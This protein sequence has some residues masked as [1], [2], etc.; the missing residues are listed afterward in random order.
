MLSDEVLHEIE[1]LPQDWHGAGSLSADVLRAI[2]RYATRMNLTRT[3]ETG[4]GKSTL[5]FSHL[6]PHHK[7]FARDDTGDGDSLRQV[8]DSALLNRSHVDFILGPTQQTLPQY[9]FSHLLQ[10]VLIDGPHGYPFPELEYYYVYPQ[11]DVNALLIIDDIH[12][13][14]IRRLFEF[15][16]ED[17]MFDFLEVVQ[18]TAFLRRN[19]TPLFHPLQDGW[20]LQAYN[21][22]RFPIGPAPARP[23]FSQTLRRWVPRPVKKLVRKIQGLSRARS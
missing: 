16:R 19:H 5:L 9:T 2:V 4:T 23:T 15:L 8:Q 10:I 1:R 6:S 13:P 21:K 7:V 20:W 11:L 18:T 22:T 14:T 3:A 12:I 17:E